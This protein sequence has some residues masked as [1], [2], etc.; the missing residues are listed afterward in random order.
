MHRTACGDGIIRAADTDGG[1]AGIHAG[2]APTP[3]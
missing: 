2:D 1:S 3:G